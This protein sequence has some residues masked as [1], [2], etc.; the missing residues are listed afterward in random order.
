MD[1]HE[2]RIDDARMA[3]AMR[4]SGARTR[5]EAVERCMRDVLKYRRQLKVLKGFGTCPCVG[6]LDAMRR[7]A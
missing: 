1:A 2:H 3:E 7:D 5:R 4:V 6:D